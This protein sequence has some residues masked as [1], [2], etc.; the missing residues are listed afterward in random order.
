MAKDHKFSVE[1]IVHEGPG[2]H[3]RAAK[4]AKKAAKKRKAKKAAKKSKR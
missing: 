1:V 2:V 3:V 4:K